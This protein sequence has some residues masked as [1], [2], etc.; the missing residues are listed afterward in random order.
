M[1]PDDPDP[2]PDRS[3]PTARRTGLEVLS[4]DPVNAQTAARSNLE[5]YLTPQGEHYIRTHHRTPDINA[6][7]WSVSL[8]GLVDDERDLSID[9]I[10]HGYSTESVVHVMECSGNGR[11]YFDPDAEGDQWTYGAVGS[12]IWT[13]TPV[14]EL[15]DSAGVDTDT[16]GDDDL[17]VSVMGG[18]AKDDED[19][20]CRSI[21]LSKVVEDC[22]LAYEMNGAPLPPEHG[23][24]IRLLVP[25]WFGNNSV[26]WIDRI[27]VME[28]MVDGPEW[29]D[30]DGRDY[31]EYQQ[32]SYRIVPAQDDDPTRYST[33][34]RIDTQ[35]QMQAP[36]E[37]RNAYLFDQLVK[38][39]VTS[40][41]GGETV[42]PDSDGAVEVTGV[43][44]A[45]DDAVERVEV[46]T[47]GGETWDEAEF[48]GP[49]L[50]R[51]AVRKFRY[52]WEAE[53]GAHTLCSRATDERG[54]VQ[55]ARISD[56]EV[57]LRGIEDD[58]YPWNKKGYGN[59]AYEP[60]GV[61]ITVE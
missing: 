27:H 34:D 55:P 42:T 16:D 58:E 19:V 25:G 6:D 18:E 21:P 39:L 51:Y 33:V 61:S 10:E 50:G 41:E 30:R 22:L 29:E 26:K 43:A 47:D 31:T 60:L 52:V 17:W 2:D 23:Y 57:G 9:E 49:D 46:S 48:V 56:P 54:R 8:S 24:P 28:E 4:A 53:S 11:A 40:F 32:S 59:N 7:D 1:A 5:S 44:W 14:R 36:E 15:L 37:I 12:A 20:Y 13:G 35:E 38:S 45:G 3:P